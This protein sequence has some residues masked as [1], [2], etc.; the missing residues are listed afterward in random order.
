[1]LERLGYDVTTTTKPTNA[2]EFF[3]SDPNRFDLVITDLTMPKMT[4]YELAL[5]LKAIRADMP[6][7]ICSGFSQSLSEQQV[8]ELDLAALVMKPILSDDLARNVRVALD[9]Q[10]QK[11]T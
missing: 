2:L 7:I 9:R 4:G 5:Q 11:E 1:M 10:A 8:K 3:R 6:I